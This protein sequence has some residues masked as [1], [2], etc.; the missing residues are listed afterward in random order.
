MLTAQTLGDALNTLDT[1]ALG[2]EEMAAFYVKRP[3]LKTAQ[4]I[5]ELLHTDAPRK[6]LFIGH[7]RP[8]D[9][10]PAK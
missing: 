3:R 2:A 4:L 7:H 6:F 1:D 8:R 9:R 10:R 5:N